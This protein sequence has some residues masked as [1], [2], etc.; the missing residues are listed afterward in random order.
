MWT[1]ILFQWLKSACDS[2]WTEHMKWQQ[3][4]KRIVEMKKADLFDP[5]SLSV[6]YANKLF[7]ILHNMW[8]QKAN[9]S[10]AHKLPSNL[11]S[12]QIVILWGVCMCFCS[13]LLFSTI[14]S[15]TY[16]F[17]SFVALFVCIFHDTNLIKLTTSLISLSRL[18]L[19]LLD[20]FI[21]VAKHSVN[22]VVHS[23]CIVCLQQ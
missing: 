10:N 22:M 5:L 23:M 11:V 6:I 20:A 18:L 12:A 17:S 4:E 15:H 14:F 19:L 7:N 8:H 1:I 13:F 2:A 9:I 3:I 16:G 21:P